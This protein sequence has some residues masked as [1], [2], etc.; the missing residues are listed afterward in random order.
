MV[1]H[2]PKLVETGPNWVGFAEFGPMLPSIGPKLSEL[3]PFAMLVDIGPKL[4]E[5]GPNLAQF[6]VP[7]SCIYDLLFVIFIA[8]TYG[9]HHFLSAPEPIK[10]YLGLARPTSAWV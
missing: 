1:E 8:G 6:G 5:L 4:V 2:R 3:C 9:W 7:C 10:P